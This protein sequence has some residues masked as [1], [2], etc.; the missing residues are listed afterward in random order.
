ME[1]VVLTRCI[2]TG[3]ERLTKMTIEDELN[4]AKSKL[5]DGMG[6]YVY[7]VCVCVCV[8][9]CEWVSER[10]REREREREGG[11]RDVSWTAQ[12]KIGS[13]L[14]LKTTADLATY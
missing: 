4:Y 5:Q 14:F 12:L 3:D 7:R 11:G 13:T 8:C 6:L 10:E 1:S 9:V 2:A